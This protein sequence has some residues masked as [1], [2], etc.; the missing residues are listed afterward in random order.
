L[1]PLTNVI[2]SGSF[3]R[4]PIASPLTFALFVNSFNEL[5]HDFKKIVSSIKRAA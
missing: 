1:Q 5:M 4:L 3:L 2:T